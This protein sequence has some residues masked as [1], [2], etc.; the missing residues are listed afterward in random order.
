MGNSNCCVSERPPAPKGISAIPRMDEKGESNIPVIHANSRFMSAAEG[1]RLVDAENQKKFLEETLMDHEERLGPKHWSLATSLE[2]LSD[3]Y[4]ELGNARK[5]KELLER[6]L[7]IKERSHGPSHPNITQVLAKLAAAEGRLGD[8]P[9][10]IELLEK[11]VAISCKHYGYSAIELADKLRDLGIAYGMVNYAR[12]MRDNLSRALEIEEK[13]H[14]KDHEEI[15][16]TLFNLA[17][18]H[19]ALGEPDVREAMLQRGLKILYSSKKEHRDLIIFAENHCR[20]RS[21]SAY[22]QETTASQHSSSIGERP[23]GEL[24]SAKTL[25]D[26]E[27]SHMAETPLSKQPTIPTGPGEFL[28]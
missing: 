7:N 19:G 2:N 17:M 22:S 3:I 6:A 13:Y 9:R 26:D 24:G 23:A 16:P 21:A 20:K 18:A 5:Q 27:C 12:K 28:V 4:G 25:T 15:C 11:V 1:A 10:E 8:H 14:G